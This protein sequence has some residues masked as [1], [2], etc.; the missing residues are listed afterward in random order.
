MIMG[1]FHH[2]ALHCIKIHNHNT[3]HHLAQSNNMFHVFKSIQCAFHRTTETCNADIIY[4]M[5]IYSSQ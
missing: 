4:S 5:I 2:S 1:K 3:M